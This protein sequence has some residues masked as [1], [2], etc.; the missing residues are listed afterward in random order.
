MWYKPV[1]IIDTV[2]K[3][4]I[5]LRILETSSRLT[6]AVLKK[7]LSRKFSYAYMIIY[8]VISLFIQNL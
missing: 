1:P 8:S 6:H 3:S 2:H 4:K 5:N 7:C